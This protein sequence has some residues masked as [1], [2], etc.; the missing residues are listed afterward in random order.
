MD[1]SRAVVSWSRSNTR[2]RS[3]TRT[4]SAFGAV[5]DTKPLRME[6]RLL[7]SNLPSLAFVPAPDNP[8][9]F[10]HGYRRCGPCCEGME[11]QTS[12]HSSV[13]ELSDGPLYS[14]SIPDR[15]RFGLLHMWFDDYVRSNWEKRTSH[16]RQRELSVLEIG[17]FEGASTSW[18]LDDLMSHP[19]S[20]IDNN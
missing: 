1:A 20:K 7:K 9:D 19:K 12:L 13:S 10:P 15:S 17:C 5:W 4:E 11:S 18:L 2:V 16:L 8:S 3:N 6:K 14:Q